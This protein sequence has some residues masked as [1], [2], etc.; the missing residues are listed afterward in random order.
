[1]P[2]C[3]IIRIKILS[4]RFFSQRFL[5]NDA[6]HSVSSPALFSD[7]LALSNPARQTMWTQVA[8]WSNG[9]KSS[10]FDIS[11][12]CLGFCASLPRHS[13]PGRVR[14]SKEQGYL[15]SN[16]ARQTMW[17]QVAPWSNGSKSSHLD[18]S[19]GCLGLYAIGLVVVVPRVGEWGERHPKISSCTARLDLLG[20]MHA[21][22]SSLESI[23][24][25]STKTQPQRPRSSI[26]FHA[27][28]NLS[29]L[30]ICPNQSP[31]E[32][33]STVSIERANSPAGN[34]SPHRRF[35]SSSSHFR[36]KSNDNRPYIIRLRGLEPFLFDS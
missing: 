36:I 30:I 10:H 31:H 35:P 3:T 27:A 2:H 29:A 5:V 6:E 7:L 22:P 25:Q 13:L 15:I 21:H 19:N 8:P 12:G 4:D 34:R 18:I 33:T 1:V 16:P 17:T 14:N 20:S 9:S 24:N 26:H 28:T 23:L 11:N 32:R